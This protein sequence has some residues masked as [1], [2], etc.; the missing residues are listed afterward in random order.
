MGA[1]CAVFSCLSMAASTGACILAQPRS[2]V[3]FTHRRARRSRTISRSGIICE[4]TPRRPAAYGHLKKRLALTFADDI[5][6]YVEAKTAFRT[7]I[8]RK[9]RSPMTSSLTSSEG[10]LDLRPSPRSLQGMSTVNRRA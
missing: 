8:L 2:E 4:P 10:A 3:P 6:G 9:R 1:A 5:D 7:A